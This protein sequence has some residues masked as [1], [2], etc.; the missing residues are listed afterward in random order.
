[1]ETIR[2][3]WQVP[4]DLH[5]LFYKDEEGYHV[6]HCLDFD[7]VAA[8]KSREKASEKLRVC[9]EVYY[10]VIFRVL[11]EGGIF[12]NPCAPGRYWARFIRAGGEREFKMAVAPTKVLTG[13]KSCRV[14]ERREGGEDGH[15]NG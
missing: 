14:M 15:E 10:D 5:F 9:V 12:T 6:A 1:M 8:S 13:W 7:L 2:A 4:R 3:E 11:G